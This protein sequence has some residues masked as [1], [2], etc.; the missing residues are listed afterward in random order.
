[1][2]DAGQLTSTA[3]QVYDEFFVPA[4]FGAWAPRVVAAAALRPGMRVVDVACGTGV[5]TLEA[6][7]AT[8]P[9]GAVVGVDLNPGMLAVA[10][11]KSEEIEWHEGPAEALPFDASTFDATV[12]QFG[13]MF[14]GDPQAGVSE[15]WRVLR[16]GGRLVIAVWDALDNTP[17]Y[18][19]ITSL[20]ARLFGDA[21][22]ALLHAPYSLG[23]PDALLA[24]L[25]ASGVADVTVQRLPG[26]ARF[27]SIRSWMHTDVRGWTLAD[28]LD[29][30][31]YER[32]VSEAEHELSGF[33][34]ADGT[35]RFSHP[36][37]LATAKKQ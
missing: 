17:G 1:M 28:K 6:A 11:G 13:L 33:V 7:K 30:E 22:A 19:A 15:M 10:R 20:L 37:L 24:L 23:D 12:S 34:T 18:A 31:Q 2:G 14:F 16:P 27:A 8:S 25:R 3:A 36:A 32:L 4:L 9:G 35:V 21:V 29:D 5:L 26:E